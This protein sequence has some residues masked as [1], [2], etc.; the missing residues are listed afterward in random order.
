MTCYRN[1]SGPDLG[2][3][4]K[5]ANFC[6]RTWNQNLAA[7]DYHVIFWPADDLDNERSGR[8]LVLRW[9][10]RHKGNSKATV[11]N[12]TFRY[13]IPPHFVRHSNT[14]LPKQSCGN[15]WPWLK[16]LLGTVVNSPPAGAFPTLEI[17][18]R[19]HLLLIIVSCLQLPS[20]SRFAWN[21]LIR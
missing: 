11:K 2:C 3:T 4:S 13:H 12:N 20:V 6:S 5:F 16:Q 8:F 9:G 18:Q 7:N 1:S 19:P 14:V 21:T 17:L 15:F 10:G